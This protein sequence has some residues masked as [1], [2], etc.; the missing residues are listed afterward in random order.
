MWVRLRIRGREIRAGVRS[1]R[2]RC[3]AAQRGLAGCIRSGRSLSQEAAGLHSWR[4]LIGCCAHSPLWF[5]L[6]GA[7]ARCAG[8]QALSEFYDVAERPRRE[9]TH[10]VVIRLSLGSFTGRNG[11]KPAAG[12]GANTEELSP[13]C[14]THAAGRGSALFSHDP[15]GQ[16]RWSGSWLVKGWQLLL[17]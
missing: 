13:S 11:R 2:E 4:G 9:P 15:T 16:D 5:N 17:R 8:S 14:L 1:R 3:K 10:P 6:S 12:Q 7:G